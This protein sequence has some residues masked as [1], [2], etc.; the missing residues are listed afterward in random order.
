MEAIYT[1][2]GNVADYLAWTERA[3]IQLD[4]AQ[5]EILKCVV[6]ARAQGASWAEIGKRLG[7]TKQAAQQR[8]GKAVTEAPKVSSKDRS[9]WVRPEVFAAPASA[10]AAQATED[11]AAHVEA[12]ATFLDAQAPAPAAG[13]D[14][15]SYYCGHRDSDSFNARVCDWTIVYPMEESCEAMQEI[16]VHEQM[17]LD[18]DQEQAEPTIEEIRQRTVETHRKNV[19]DANKR[20]LDILNAL[21]PSSATQKFYDRAQQQ[22]LELDVNFNAESGQ[23]SVFA[24]TDDPSD[25]MI[26]CSQFPGQ[27]GKGY[28]H[29]YSYTTYAADQWKDCSYATAVSRMKAMTEN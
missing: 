11:H 7:M 29:Y 15:E 8:Y 13:P 22:G 25:G 5:E 21:G 17:H 6:G 27:D 20:N 26:L 1:D 16:Y 2:L 10:A 23:L 19:E 12:T 14:T 18:T 4:E 24:K 28:R 3:K 9:A